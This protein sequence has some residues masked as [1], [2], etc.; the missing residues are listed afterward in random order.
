MTNKQE[1]KF[2]RDLMSDYLLT[3][4]PEEERGNTQRSFWIEDR[5]CFFQVKHPESEYHKI[6][7]LGKSQ[8]GHDKWIVAIK[9]SFS[10]TREA[11][12]KTSCY[13]IT[14]AEGI[15]FNN[16]TI[17]NVHTKYSVYTYLPYK[18]KDKDGNIIEGLLD[19]IPNLE[20]G[21]YLFKMFSKGH[22]ILKIGKSTNVKQRYRNCLTTSP[23]MESVGYISTYDFDLHENLLHAKFDHLKYKRE[24][25]YYSEEIIS[26]FIN[27][28]NWIPLANLD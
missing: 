18:A 3:F 15:I 1:E 13:K 11:Y 4:L 8:K 10:L 19:V 21:V 16:S 5:P 28:P 14:F 24:W 17:I 9:D 20:S 23:D 2:K 12:F 25:F 26:Y 27:H 7:F 22:E 6:K